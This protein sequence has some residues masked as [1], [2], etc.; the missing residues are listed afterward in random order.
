M[1]FITKLSLACASIAMMASSLS[2]AGTVPANALFDN[3]VG[4]DGGNQSTQDVY[5]GANYDIEWMT[6]DRSVAGELTVQIKSAFI[7]HN[8][9]SYYDLGDLFIMDR[10]DYTE[11]DQCSDG[12]GRVGCNE[13][14]HQATSDTKKSTNQ[15]QYAFD[16]GGNRDSNRYNQHGNL[17]DI[18]NTGYTSYSSDVIKTGESGGHRGWQ[19]IM[20]KN[21]PSAVGS[22][23]HWSTNTYSDILTMT[24]DISA[25]TLMDAAQLAFRWQ[26]TCANDIIEV[27]TGPKS[28]NTTVPEPGTLMLML[29]AGLGLFASRQKQVR[30]SKV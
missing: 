2:Y 14:S 5:G 19:V 28:G 29:L 17:R 12:S 11:A 1:K 21:A 15:W 27:V 18:A 23:G 26:M 30:N 7:S 8:T 16:L 25:S 10:D 13:S 22:G 4:A 6:V 24:F 9:S 20:S 3:Y